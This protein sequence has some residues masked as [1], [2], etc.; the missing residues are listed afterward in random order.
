MSNSDKPLGSWPD[1]I[2]PALPQVA[3]LH[4]NA[5]HITVIWQRIRLDAVRRVKVR[6]MKCSEVKSRLSPLMDSA[7]TDEEMRAAAGHIRQCEACRDELAA[8]S[9]SRRLVSS[10]GQQKAPPELASKL[11]VAMARELAR[12][13]VAREES[14]RDRWRDLFNALVIPATAGAVTAILAFGWLLEVLVSA[15]ARG[16]SDIPIG[17]YTPPALTFSPFLSTMSAGSA[18]SIVLEA[19]VDAHGRVQDY[20]I[21][22]APENPG[23]LM[24]ELK[25]ILIFTVFRPATRFGQPASGRVILSFSK[26][27]VKG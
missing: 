17:L 21:L 22:S 3:I 23:A 14:G 15:P 4:N 11:Q 16:M 20:R 19:Y 9:T 12:G 27:N 8:L 25:N 7:M 5:V 2:N 10:L 13:R 26:I 1:G 18:D 6:P 24:P